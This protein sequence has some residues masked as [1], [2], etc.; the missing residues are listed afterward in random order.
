[1]VQTTSCY[2]FV[3]D[4]QRA[5]LLT[6]F[7]QSLQVASLRGNNSHV[8]SNGLDD[9]RRD[10]IFMLEKYAFDSLEIVIGHV[11]RQRRQRWRH[12]R[13]LRN[14]KRSEAGT[15]LRQKTVRMP[16]IA[17]FEF[18]NKVS[19]RR[20]ARQPYSAHR[21]FCAARNKANLFNTWNRPRNQRG[22][23]QLQLSRH[24][25]TGAAARLVGNGLADGGIRMS[26][27][28]RAPGAHIVEKLVSVRV[29]EMLSAA[30]L[31]DQR[32]STYP[33]E[34]PHGTVHHTKHHLLCALENLARTLALAF[35]SGLRGVLVL[36]IRS[37]LLH[38]PRRILC[39]SRTT[40]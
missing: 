11:Q 33:P 24:A 15:R 31:H 8:R 13:T 27:D 29:V 32:F 4:K 30:A 34:R 22:Q 19:L 7:L 40:A 25:K 28:H 16:V 12:S 21:C 23:L 18:D 38:P 17:A 1:M 10:L 6:D 37:S 3:H 26:Q 36:S 14:T 39:T 20:P 35:Q 5:V 9:D 2:P